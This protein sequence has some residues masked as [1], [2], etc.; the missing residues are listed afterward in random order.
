M[1]LL[2][3]KNK[4]YF[5]VCNVLCMGSAR[6]GLGGAIATPR[7]A[8]CEYY[9]IF[10]TW[11]ISLDNVSNLLTLITYISQNTLI[12]YPSIWS[13]I[14][15][16]LN[17][18]SNVA[19]LWSMIMTICLHNMEQEL[20]VHELVRWEL[21]VVGSYGFTCNSFGTRGCCWW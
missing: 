18:G 17:N 4:S 10:N 3:L 7:I 13:M 2:Y 6:E 11:I 14:C 8:I 16:R 5:T 21:S 20:H 9:N 15:S 19:R 12:T 1:E